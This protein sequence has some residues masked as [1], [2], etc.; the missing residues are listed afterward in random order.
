MKKVTA[1]NP[2]PTLWARRTTG[3][4][5]QT[6]FPIAGAPRLGG[7]VI[8]TALM[9]AIFTVAPASAQITCTDLYTLVKPANVEYFRPDGPIPVAGEQVVGYGYLTPTESDDRAMFWTPSSPDGIDLSP[10][11]FTYSRALGTCVAQQVGYAGSLATGGHHAMLWSGSGGSAIELHPSGFLYSEAFGT[12]GAKQ[13]GRGVLPGGGGIHALLWSGSA[14]TAVDLNPIG[15]QYSEATA[16]KGT[17]QVG[18]G[19]GVSTLNAEHA[20]VWNGSATNFVDL[21]PD[22]LE[23][24]TARA[25]NGVQQVGSGEGP[26]TAFYSHALLWSGTAN[27]CVDLNPNEVLNSSAFAISDTYQAGVGDYHALLWRGSAD[28]VVD[29]HSVLPGDVFMR[30]CAYSIEGSTVFGWGIDYSFN[31]HVI[32]WNIPEPA[33]AALPSAII[34]IVTALRRSRNDQ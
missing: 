18:Y 15:F 21:N 10:S 30:S 8:A 32:A 31:Y 22:W 34:V 17:Q 3:R 28:S 9:L 16:V 1:M 6:A 12:S 29:L 7:G 11:G 25:T 26:T 33:S 4:A 2:A 14:A 13:V 5:A 20:L 24:S 19:F 23:Y 27:S